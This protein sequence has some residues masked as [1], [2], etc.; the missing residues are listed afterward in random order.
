MS[1]FNLNSVKANVQL[2]WN[3]QLNKKTIQMKEEM[4]EGIA[5]TRVDLLKNW[6]YDRWVSLEN[7]A[8]IIAQTEHRFLESFLQESKEKSTYFTELFL[9]DSTLKGF[10]SS[11]SRHAGKIYSDDK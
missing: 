11:Y 5:K 3:Y 7:R 4:F 2:W 9:I 1:K 6:T 10:A 8:Q